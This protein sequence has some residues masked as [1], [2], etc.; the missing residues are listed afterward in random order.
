MLAVALKM[1]QT[2]LLRLQVFLRKGRGRGEAAKE[3]TR[4]AWSV[5]S[6]YGLA[7]C[8][9]DAPAAKACKCCI[10]QTLGILQRVLSVPSELGTEPVG[11][12][13]R[14]APCSPRAIPTVLSPHATTPTATACQEKPAIDKVP[15]ARGWPAAAGVAQCRCAN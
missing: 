11:S 15:L 2:Q 14:P 9:Q 7:D 3:K 13:T 12:S 10:F 4:N 1:S 5:R 6:K 8:F